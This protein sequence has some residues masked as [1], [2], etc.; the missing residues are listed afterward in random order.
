VPQQD[1]WFPVEE[2]RQRVSRV[3]ALMRDA[4]VDVLL[5]FH[6]ASVTWLTGF[7]STAYMLFSVAIVPAT[8]DPLTV[9]RD[10]EEYWLRRTGAFAE[11]EFWVDG[12]GGNPAA[13]VKRALSR[14][15]ATDA[16][17]GVESAFP[18]GIGLADG[19]RA[20]LPNA[21][22]VDL[23]AA[24]VA[25]LREVKSPAEIEYM[26]RASR[27][28]EAGTAAGIAATHAGA[29]EREIAALSEQ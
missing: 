23:G 11:H 2:Y 1:L 7:F 13:I 8:G 19:L 18:Y 21:T 16:R 5:A 3:Q 17:I 29:T 28:V 24:L 15:G 22:L 26:R 10:N 9:C 6:P 12:E 14:I 27:A 4:G 20:E 25:R